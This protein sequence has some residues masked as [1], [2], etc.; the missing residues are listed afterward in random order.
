[1]LL[2]RR[3]LFFLLPPEEEV[4]GAVFAFEKRLRS[5]RSER[6]GGASPPAT[7]HRRPKSSWRCAPRTRRRRR[8]I[9]RLRATLWSQVY[10]G[11]RPAC[12][13]LPVA[14]L[15]RSK[16][17]SL[18][19]KRGEGAPRRRRRSSP[20]RNSICT[21]KGDG[22]ATRGSP[23]KLAKVNCPFGCCWHANDPP[24]CRWYRLHF[25]CFV[26]VDYGTICM[27]IAPNAFQMSSGRFRY[28]LRL[29][30]RK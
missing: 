29:L 2:H 15:R 6:R 9:R 3:D 12:K 7:F 4:G 13:W 30:F 16:L 21:A 10:D 27:E 24:D 19:S 20:P 28:A 8:E 23:L 5:H 18:G 22:E 14:R 25:E 11:C 17:P 26:C 1:M